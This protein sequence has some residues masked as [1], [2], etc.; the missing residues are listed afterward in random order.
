MALLDTTR[1]RLAGRIVRDEE[2]LDGAE[3]HIGIRDEMIVR[4]FGRFVVR[5]EAQ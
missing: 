2:Q 4:E 5:G 3:I 1:A